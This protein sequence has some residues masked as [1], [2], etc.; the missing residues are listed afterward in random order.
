MSAATDDRSMRDDA[1]SGVT[2]RDRERIA[3]TPAHDVALDCLAAGITAA[4]PD[5]LIPNAVSV[6]DGIL[7]I[8][9]AEGVRVGSE[10]GEYDL[11]DYDRIMLLGAGKASAEVAA[12][13][14]NVLRAADRDVAEGVVITED[15]ETR[16]SP[17]GV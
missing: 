3:R 13:L 2:F 12:A 14:V 15:P 11:A 8:E 16:P 1:D 5:R 7:R 10:L 4:R 17:A 9:G 6:R